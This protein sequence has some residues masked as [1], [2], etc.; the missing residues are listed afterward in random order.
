MTR[1]EQAVNIAQT[2][3]EDIRIATQR[4]Y[5]RNKQKQVL[6]DVKDA[7]EVFTGEEYSRGIYCSSCQTALFVKLGEVFEAYM[8]VGSTETNQISTETTELIP[9]AQ[10]ETESTKRAKNGT[11][12]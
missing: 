5:V 4:G 12:E 6:R 8:T 10:K 2:F 1:I 9:E 7:I 11:S 3:S